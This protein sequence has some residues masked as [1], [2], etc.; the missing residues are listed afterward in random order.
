MS[1]SVV[2][3]ALATSSRSMPFSPPLGHGNA[4][5]PCSGRGRQRLGGPRRQLLAEFVEAD[6]YRI[7]VHQQRAMGRHGLGDAGD[8]LG[9]DGAIERQHAPVGGIVDGAAELHRDGGIA[10]RQPAREGSRFQA[11]DQAGWSAI[12]LACFAAERESLRAK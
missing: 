10:T 6:L 1:S 5:A 7:V 12:K 2:F 8:R 4:P 9:L 3:R 11:S